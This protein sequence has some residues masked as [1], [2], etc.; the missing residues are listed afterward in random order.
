MITRERKILSIFFLILSIIP[1]CTNV[2]VVALIIKKRQLRRARF[3]IIANLSMPDTL[4]LLLLCIG[5]IEGLQ[6]D[7]NF[8]ENIEDVLHIIARIITTSSYINSLF[9]TVFLSFDRYIAVRWS[10]QYE[11]I[12][13]KVKVILVTCFI[14]IVSIL[15]GGIQWV[16]VK[17]YADYHLHIF[18]T[19][20][21]LNI[22]KSTFILS[23]AKYTNAVRKQHMTNIQKRLNYIRVAK[24]KFDRPRYLKSSLKDSFKLF[25]CTAIIINL[26]LIL[27]IIEL[28]E[29]K[30]MFDI[31]LYVTFLI[32][33]TDLIVLLL[34]QTEIKYQLKRAF[35]RSISIQPN[36]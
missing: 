35:L 24:E 3:Y 2:R 4:M 14:W 20:S 17:T 11:A 10:L 7:I 9:T 36:C 34:T 22:T 18:V 6:E 5:A 26:Q 32:T 13:T 28:F 33:I 21:L 31:K 1:L 16:N 29:S 8:E 30:Y 25:I 19:L 12:L 23:V 27:G 15:L